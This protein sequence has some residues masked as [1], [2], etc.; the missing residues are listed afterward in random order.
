MD[1]IL[2]MAN[3]LILVVIICGG[4]MLIICAW[5]SMKA[6]ESISKDLEKLFERLTSQCKADQVID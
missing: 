6:L 3:L 1:S 4:I 5:K 2:L